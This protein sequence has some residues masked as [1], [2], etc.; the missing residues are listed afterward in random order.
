MVE[1][2]EIIALYLA[3]RDEN[4]LPDEVDAQ[5][6]VDS[7]DAILLALKAAGYRLVGPGEVDAETVERCAEIAQRHADENDAQAKKLML[8]ANKLRRIGDPFGHGDMASEGCAEVTSAQFEAQA[9]A[10]ALRS[11]SPAIQERET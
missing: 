3:L 9:I 2:R 4:V 6:R 1:A 7:A 11:L 10:T 8:R 5:E